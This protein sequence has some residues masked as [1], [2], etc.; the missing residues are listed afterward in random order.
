VANFA[1]S[2]RVWVHGDSTYDGL[3]NLNDFNALAGNFGLVA[4]PDSEILNGLSADDPRR[5]SEEV[6]L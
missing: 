2:S 6:G 3:V 1:Q 5:V 4:G